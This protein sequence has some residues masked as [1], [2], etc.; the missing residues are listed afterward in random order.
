[1]SVGIGSTK[2]LI[3]DAVSVGRWCPQG[4]LQPLAWRMSACARCAAGDPPAS[5]YTWVRC[6]EGHLN[7]RADY[8][9]LHGCN[10]CK[11]AAR[12]A[13]PEQYARHLEANRNAAA[14]RRR[15]A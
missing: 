8:E 5:T 3:G 11:N 7:R 14:R 9:R 12:R 1:M 15:A 4:H 6:R 13:D 2:T 10:V